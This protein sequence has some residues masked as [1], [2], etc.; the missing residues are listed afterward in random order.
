[1][2]D[3]SDRDFIRVKI[4][5]H[6]SV[7]LKVAWSG[8]SWEF[9]PYLIDL[10]VVSEVSQRVRAALSHLVKESMRGGAARSGALIHSLAQAGFDLYGA[11]F[12]S[13]IGSEIS[14]DEIRLW[15]Q[16]Q[17]GKLFWMSFSVDNRV[18]IPWGLVYD[19]DPAQLSG[20]PDDT[21]IEHYQNFWC[22]KHALSTMYSRMLPF[23]LQ[24]HVSQENLRVLAAVNRAA[25]ETALDVL[26][27]PDRAIWE[28]VQSR[29]WNPKYSTRELFDFW[30]SSGGDVH[31]LYFYCHA[32]GNTIALGDD[33]ELTM[34]KYKLNIRR[35]GLGQHEA[36]CLVFL[37]GCSTAVGDPSGGFLEAAGAPG[38][39][40]FIGTE[41]EVPNVFA[42]R[43]G[44][45]FLYYFCCKGQ[46]ILAIM[47]R[48]R[49][50]HWPLSLAYSTY[51][52]P[53]LAVLPSE[54][55]ALEFEE[56]FSLTQLG[57]GVM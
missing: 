26:S 30:K 37:N 19:T 4:A 8:K 46:S 5:L 47:D 7:T 52:Y 22:L 44:L 27:E 14:G 24:E 43:F 49:R 13:Q 35:N 56:N 33:D 39:S 38:F 40:G 3:L 25:F 11:L 17:E 23:G 9:P 36:S 16:R 31:L 32:N 20:E 34:A 42:L 10:G 48:L 18:H 15:L 51:C 54:M 1:M 28:T 2:T 53:L 50:Q 12:L 21:T 6:D 55:P 41:T 45:A 57:T 29:F